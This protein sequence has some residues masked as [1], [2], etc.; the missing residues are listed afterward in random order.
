MVRQSLATIN[1]A[2]VRY[3]LC[4]LFPR[5]VTKRLITTLSTDRCGHFQGLI[6]LSCYETANLYFS[7]SVSFFGFQIPIYD[8]T[9]ISCYTH[10][11]YQ[12]GTEVTLY[13]NSLFAPLVHA[14]PS[15]RCAGEL[16]SVPR[17]WQRPA[18]PNLRR[19]PGSER[20]TTLG[21]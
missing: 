3:I 1:E 21:Q 4:L 14:L 9:P 12:C 5:F 18:Q 17:A 7:A 19:Q 20:V 15:D 10:W 2:A 16:C 8:P 11:N 6:F 13:T